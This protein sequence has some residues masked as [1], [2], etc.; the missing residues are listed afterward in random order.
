MYKIL[1]IEN[2][3]LI[4]KYDKLELEYNVLKTEIDEL[5]NIIPETIIPET[6][7]PE[8]II[9]EQPT[10]FY[11]VPFNKQCMYCRKKK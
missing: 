7:L 4:K 6:I 10:P 1:L 5:N 2:E 9:V 11:V 8:T 3:S